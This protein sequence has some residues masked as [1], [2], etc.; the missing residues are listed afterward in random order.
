[1]SPVKPFFF[2]F[3]LMYL[4]TRIPFYFFLWAKLPYPLQRGRNKDEME[5]DQIST[6]VSNVIPISSLYFCCIPYRICCSRKHTPDL[7]LFDVKTNRNSQKKI[8]LK[9]IVFEKNYLHDSE[10]KKTCHLLFNMKLVTFKNLSVIFQSCS[11]TH[12]MEFSKHI[13]ILE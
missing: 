1:M 13:S 7:S 11:E 6:W 10:K 9:K 12:L 4:L 8:V 2:F 3:P 5:A